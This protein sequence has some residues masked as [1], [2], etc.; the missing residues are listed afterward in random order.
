M[1]V[2]ILPTTV[3]ETPGHGLTG[4]VVDGVL[5][6]DAGQLG[7]SGT[8]EEQSRIENV[9]LTHSHIDHVAGLPMFLDNV[10]GLADKPPTICAQCRRSMRCKPICSAVSCGPIS[11]ASPK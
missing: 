1:R 2:H 6:L 4:F 9:L 11:S 3:Y 8:C 7:Q 10:Y 5:A